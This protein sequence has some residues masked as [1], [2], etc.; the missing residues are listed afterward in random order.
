MAFLRRKRRYGRRRFGMLRRRRRFVGRR[1]RRRLFRAR[2][3]LHWPTS[4]GPEWKKYSG[5]LSNIGCN[6]AFNAIN[7]TSNIGLGTG[8]NQRIGSKIIVRKVECFFNIFAN[9]A[10]SQ[11][12]A[13]LVIW[14]L[15]NKISEAPASVQQI[16]D[17]VNGTVPT[18]VVIGCGKVGHNHNYRVLYKRGVRINPVA[19]AAQANPQGVFQYVR[20]LTLRWRR[21]LRVVY[22]DGVDVPGQNKCNQLQADMFGTDWFGTAPA[23]QPVGNF[24]WVV[25]FNDA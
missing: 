21:G 6:H 20:H 25:W 2:R 11:E 16:F 7:L 24:Y 15:K 23:T 18:S 8:V 19:N 10:V 5:E 3:R 17:T 1:P 14:R 9:T 12:I 22:N 13:R 4:R